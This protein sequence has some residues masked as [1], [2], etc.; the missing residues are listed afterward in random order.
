MSNFT[1]IATNVVN[2]K[3]Q[4]KRYVFKMKPE[5]LQHLPTFALPYY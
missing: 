2:D 4:R 5:E 1:E 3:K